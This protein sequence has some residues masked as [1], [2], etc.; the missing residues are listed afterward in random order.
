M[1]GCWSSF[2]VECVSNR[3]HCMIQSFSHALVHTPQTPEITNLH[4]SLTYVSF[5]VIGGSLPTLSR[6]SFA[7][8]GHHFNLQLAL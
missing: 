3:S 1:L 8:Y 2:S 4:Y 7:L 6:S 5:S